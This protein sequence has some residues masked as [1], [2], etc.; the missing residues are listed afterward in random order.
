M[1]HAVCAAQRAA[2]RQPGPSRGDP[3]GWAER[4]PTPTAGCLDR[5]SFG[6]TVDHRV[7]ACGLA[8]QRRDQLHH[9][10]AVSGADPDLRAVST[11][12]GCAPRE[13]DRSRTPVRHR[14]SAC[15]CAAATRRWR[16]GGT[17]VSSLPNLR[18]WAGLRRACARRRAGP[19]SLGAVGCVGRAPGPRW[20]GSRSK[21]GL[22]DCLS[23]PS[24]PGTHAGRLAHEAGMQGGELGRHGRE[25]AAVGQALAPAK[26]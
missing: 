17:R 24:Q 10:R 1:T 19:A 14:P 25:H 4:P 16:R 6:A 15:V 9:A 22:S 11:G 3:A 23:S 5:P 13:I 20:C 21:G 26:V 12:A 18:A 8:Q 2:Q 7:G